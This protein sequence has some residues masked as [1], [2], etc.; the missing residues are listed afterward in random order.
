M[1][2]PLAAPMTIRGQTISNRI[3]MGSMHTGLEEAKDGFKS[4][5][6]FYEE[7]AKGGT[8]LIITGGVSPNWTGRLTPFAC[9][10]SFPWQISKHRKVTE[11]VHKY[12][13]KIVLQLLH[14]GRYAFHPFSAAPSKLKA[15]ISPF[16]PHE[17]SHREI[18]KTIRHFGRAARLAER[19]GY[20]GVEIMGS[21]GY[22]LNQFMTAKTNHRK[23][24]W[25]GDIVQRT[26][27]CRRVVMEVR[28]NV[29]EKFIIVYRISLMDLVEKGNTLDEVLC[30]AKILEGAGVDIFDS[31]IGWH[32]AR[33]PTIYLEV[34][35]AH[36][37]FATQKLK[38]AVNV[39]VIATNRL[40]MPEVARKVLLDGAADFVSLARP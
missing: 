13:T 39:P 40:N 21:E 23:D 35:R 7:R 9:D 32:E 2:D 8:G 30:A 31:G 17:M 4:L 38:N 25:G 20:D 28:K 37:A 33:V 11:A 15:P 3:I 12:P 16:K 22:L 34:P 24:Q 36:F 19:A 6:H 14:A 29:S 10:L 18:E 26:E 1:A 5:A 27:F